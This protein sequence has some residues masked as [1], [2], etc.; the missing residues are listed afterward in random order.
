MLE[1][2]GSRTGLEVTVAA[3][4]AFDSGRRIAQRFSCSAVGV[5]DGVIDLLGPIPIGESGTSGPGGLESEVVG[6]RGPMPFPHIVPLRR[7]CLD[8]SAAS[9]EFARA[10]ATYRYLSWRSLQI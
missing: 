3:W 1:T 9:S 10:R 5:A 8:R 4:P 2:E 6:L 7:D